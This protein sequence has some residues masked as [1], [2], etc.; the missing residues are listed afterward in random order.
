MGPSE[1]LFRASYLYIAALITLEIPVSIV[2]PGLQRA[3][4]F[5]HNSS[6]WTSRP[7]GCRG[8]T[9]GVFSPPDIPAQ[10]SQIV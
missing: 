3:I 1:V 7:A 9:L 10:E 8:Y 4:L 5:V 6:L 2:V